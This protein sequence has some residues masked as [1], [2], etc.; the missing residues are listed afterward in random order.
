[1]IKAVLKSDFKILSWT[2]GSVV[3]T[4]RLPMKAGAGVDPS[5]GTKIP[6]VLWCGQKKNKPQSVSLPKL[7]WRL[8]DSLETLVDLFDE[9]N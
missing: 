4:P 8:W 6:H 7:S 3:K 2:C 5:L 9:L 1:M